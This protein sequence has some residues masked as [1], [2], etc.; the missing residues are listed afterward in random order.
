MDL[1]CF[2]REDWRPLIRPAPSKRD[3]MDATPEAFAYRC[4]P[5]NIANAHGWELLSPMTFE[6]RWNGGPEL[7]DVE[8]NLPKGAEGP[9]APISNF[10]SG[11]LT[12]HVEG[13]FRTPPGWN[14][15]VGG[16][17]NQLKDGIQPLTGIVE[18]DWSPFTF[19][20]NWRFTR[21]DHWVRF[22]A[23][24]PICFFFPIQR[25]VVEATMP[26]CLPIA[27]EPELKRRFTE[28]SASRNQFTYDLKA[29]P[30]DGKPEGS[31]SGKIAGPTAKWQ[32]H[33]FRGVTLDAA[34]GPDDHQTKVRPKAFQGLP[35]GKLQ[36]GKPSPRPK[37]P[38]PAATGEALALRKRDW[39]LHTLE[40]QRRLSPRAAGI[41]ARSEV[42]RD[43]FLARYYAPATPVILT[44]AVADWPAC[45]LW[46][47]DYLRA[48]VGAQVV[49]CRLRP[50]AALAD[51]GVE[52]QA[53][54][55]D[56]LT[57]MLG[58]QG[59][60]LE[61]LTTFQSARNRQVLSVLDADLGFLD[62]LLTRENPDYHGLKS[63]GPPKS[64][65][66]LHHALTNILI[67]QVV[68]SKHIR[69]APPA[70]VSRMYNSNHVYSDVS[71]LEDPT[72]LQNFPEA[73]E[74]AVL[75]L[76]LEAGSV[77][78]VPVGWW[79][80]ARSLSFDVALNYN[81]FVWPNRAFADYPQ[82]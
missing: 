12:F 10:G 17:P 33:Y 65:I 46:T 70:E 55:D 59:A 80:E 32:K 76:T 3:W 27:D 67:A 36:P 73:R 19:T 35:A 53:P 42:G 44:G 56:L 82:R 54:F 21:P 57:R 30:G 13:L 60:A 22:E 66:A 24:E 52:R 62:G 1:I 50:T 14:L 28:W 23:G 18:T 43:E 71:S 25:G 37:P 77:L 4:L 41:E 49:D 11:T 39:L 15:W 38:P 2:L 72:A 20:M 5:L 45:Q 47:P 6:A 26:V 9:R 58:P 69:L 34:A 51:T 63:I 40:A 64:H 8:I 75:Q 29:R 68:G 78:F 31:E 79:L 74:A 61:P 7:T 16:S 81:G 48:M